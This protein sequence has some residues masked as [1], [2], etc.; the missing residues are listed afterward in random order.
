MIQIHERKP[1]ELQ[2]QF[3]PCTVWCSWCLSKTERHYVMSEGRRVFTCVYFMLRAMS[4]FREAVWRCILSNRSVTQVFRN[5]T[6]KVASGGV[7]AKVSG[8]D[9]GRA[10][11]HTKTDRHRVVGQKEGELKDREEG[12]EGHFRQR[13]GKLCLQTTNNFSQSQCF[14]K[15]NAYN[16]PFK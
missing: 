7:T 3:N 5:N 4:R 15:Y 11:A 2:T 14:L 6:H 12:E 16:N 8:P 13:A 1:H 10:S 9:L